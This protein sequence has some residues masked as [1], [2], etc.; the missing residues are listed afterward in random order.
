M[1]QITPGTKLDQYEER[2]VQDRLVEHNFDGLV[3]AIL[4]ELNGPEWGFLGM[5]S[6]RIERMGFTGFRK[7]LRR[8][9]AHHEAVRRGDV[10]ELTYIDKRAVA[11]SVECPTCGA[12]PG[13]GCRTTPK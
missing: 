7:R 10:I 12:A 13:N 9:Q 11:R 1:Y 8:L 3:R 6:H 5:N 4:L 2:E